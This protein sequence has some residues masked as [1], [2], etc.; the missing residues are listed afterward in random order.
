MFSRES[1]EELINKYCK[2]FNL[3]EIIVKDLEIYR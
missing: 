1:A 3:I 2:D